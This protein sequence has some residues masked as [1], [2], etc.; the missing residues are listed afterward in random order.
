[1]SKITNDQENANQTSKCK[2]NA[3]R[4]HLTRVSLMLSQRKR[5]SAGKDVESREALCTI[6]G[7]ANWYSHCEGQDDY[8]KK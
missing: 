3:M 7:T 8:S 1:M 6:D 4:P 2:S 5:T